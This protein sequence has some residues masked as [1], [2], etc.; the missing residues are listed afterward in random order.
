MDDFTSMET[1]RFMASLFTID[2]E[3]QVIYALDA[4]AGSGYKKSYA[5]NSRE[6]FRKQAIHHF[7]NAAFIED[8]G[9]STNSPDYRYRLTEEFLAVIRGNGTA[10][11]VSHFLSNHESLI[12]IYA[13]KKKFQK[14]PVTINGKD[15]SFSEGKHNEL[16]KAIIEE[17]GARFAPGAECLYVGDT[18]EKDLVKNE[19]RLSELGFEI[20]LHDKM[21]DVVLYRED[22]DWL[23]FIESVTSVGPMDDKRIIELQ[24]LT[25]N[26]KSGKIFVTAFLDF[27][28]FKKFSES[29]AWDTEVW[30]A[31]VP[32]H[33]I[34]L[35]GDRFLGPR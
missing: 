7:R 34:H 27:K 12:S 35:N 30:I 33:M 29:L 22:K 6:T 10:E 3:K 24:E 26:V 13:S 16:Q 18:I 25:K 1:V 23:Y 8:N 9:K 31:D 5:E 2:S 15:L 28:T 17:F 32:D 4:G 21:P 20:T 11:V 14:I 19:K